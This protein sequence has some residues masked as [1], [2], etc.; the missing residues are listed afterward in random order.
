MRRQRNGN[1]GFTLIELLLVVAILGIIAGIAIPSYMGQRRRA[2]VIGDAISNAKVMAM[3]LEARK[4]ERG[5]YGAAGDYKWEAGV[6][7]GAA[8]TLLPHF[9]ADKGSTKMN[10]TLAITGTGLTYE[11]TVTDPSMS[12]APTAYKTNQIGEELERM[13]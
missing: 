11:L 10:Y 3:Q 8:A 1:K 6:A 13:K 5:T 4:A 2:R 12:G 7:D 9:S